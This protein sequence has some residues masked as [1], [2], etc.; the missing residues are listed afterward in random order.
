MWN[1]NTNFKDHVNPHPH[2][3]E[4]FRGQQQAVLPG[5]WVAGCCPGADDLFFFFFFLEVNVQSMEKMVNIVVQVC[6]I[7]GCGI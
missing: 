3:Q 4:L 1:V 7:G 2:R 5:F 6:R